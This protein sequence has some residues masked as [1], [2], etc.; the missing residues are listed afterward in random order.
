[1]ASS[2]HDDLLPQ[3]V[4]DDGAGGAPLALSMLAHVASDQ[5]PGVAGGE[6]ETEGAC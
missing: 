4:A 5:A 2:A 6:A 3:D 1:M